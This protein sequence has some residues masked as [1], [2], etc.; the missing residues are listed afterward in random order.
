MKLSIAVLVATFIAAMG[1]SAVP[2]EF[3]V[4][5]QEKEPLPIGLV[6]EEDRPVLDVLHVS[7]RRKRN[8]VAEWMRALRC[9]LRK[10]DHLRLVRFFEVLFWS[11][12]IRVSWKEAAPSRWF[13]LRSYGNSNRAAST[14]LVLGIRNGS[15]ETEA[16]SH[17]NSI[18]K[19]RGSS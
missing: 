4:N 14:P 9:L 8:C 5:V 13:R 6:G 1:A 15:D 3:S 17:R 12:N 16:R 2:A 18:Q 10:P 19:R 7:R 11:T